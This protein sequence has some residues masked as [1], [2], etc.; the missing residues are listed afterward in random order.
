MQ[1]E[2]ESCPFRWYETRASQTKETQ[3]QIG[4]TEEKKKNKKYTV[5]LR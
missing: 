1:S 5:I 4:E 2:N 3:Q